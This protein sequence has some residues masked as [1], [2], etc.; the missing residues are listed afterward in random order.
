MDEFDLGPRALIFGY[1]N[2]LFT[3]S[4]LI[5]HGVFHAASKDL[6]IFRFSY[7]FSGHA[8]GM[9]KNYKLINLIIRF[10]I[11]LIYHFTKALFYSIKL[12]SLVL[13]YAFIK[14]IFRF[15]YTL[16][17]TLRLRKEVQKNR[18]IKNDIFLDIKPP[19]FR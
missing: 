9:F 14:S 6:K 5:H 11:F 10:P 15:M 8:R 18:R 7:L 19:K 12:N 17:D 2:F 1:K 13:F 16:S 4:Y 3:K